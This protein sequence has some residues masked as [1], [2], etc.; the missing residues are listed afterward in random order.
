M[1]NKKVILQVL[2]AFIECT[3]VF[4]QTNVPLI[5]DPRVEAFT[6]FG[7]VPVSHTTGVPD[8]SIPLFNIES[9]GYTLP[10]TLRYHTAMVKPPYDHTNV[11]TG[12]IVEVG[13]TVVQNINGENDF[14]GKRPTTANWKND[15]GLTDQTVSSTQEYLVNA[16][17]RVY[18]CEYD[19]FSCSYPG[20][21]DK[22]IVNKNSSG[23]YDVIPLSNPNL[24]GSVIV[25]DYS[26]A[27]YKVNN[28]SVTDQNGYKYSYEKK[29]YSQVDVD[30][31]PFYMLDT[32]YSPNGHRL[33][34]FSYSA[35]TNTTNQ[36]NFRNYIINHDWTEYFQ[37]T[38]DFTGVAL[39]EGYSTWNSTLLNEN[40]S[41]GT[42]NKVEFDNGSL[43]FTLSSNHS[44]ITAI[45]LKDA[46]GN[47]LRNIE[48]QIG[49]FPGEG[50]RSLNK[51][52]LKDKNSVKISEYSFDYYNK[53]E[54]VN[55][56]TLN[57]D[58]W[59]Y[60]TSGYRPSGLL[61]QYIDI[62][63]RSFSYNRVL[64]MYEG[65]Q[66]ATLTIGQDINKEPNLNSTETYA[67]KSITYPTNGRTEF[68]YGLNQY[69][70]QYQ[71]Q[72][73]KTGG[74]LRIE[75]IIN[76]D[77]NSNQTAVKAYQYEPGSV[78][79][80]FSNDA[81]NF[82][83]SYLFQSY[84][85]SNYFYYYTRTQ[86]VSV[87]NGIINQEKSKEIRYSKVT[88]FSGTSTNNIGKTIYEYNFSNPH[89]YNYFDLIYNQEKLILGGN[90]WQYILE[91]RDWDNG[92]L[93]T[94]TIFKNNGNGYNITS[95]EKYNYTKTDLQTFENLKIYPYANYGGGAINLAQ[96]DS[97]NFFKTNANNALT[98]T[99]PLIPYNYSIKTGVSR[100]TSKVNTLYNNDG[101]QISTTEQFNY[102]NGAEKLM[103][104]KEITNSDAKISKTTYKYPYD[105]TNTATS[106]MVQ[107]NMIS[108]VVEE[109]SEVNGVH[110][111]G[112]KTDFGFLNTDGTLSTTSSLPSS[113]VIL[114][115]AIYKWNTGGFYDQEYTFDRYNNKENLLQYH[116][117]DNLN[118]S[119]IWGYNYQYPIAEIKNATYAQVTAA[120]Q[121]TTPDQLAA[122]ST[123]DISKVSA[124]WQTLPNAQVSTY[125]YTPFVGMTTASVPRGVSTNYAYDTYNRLY[126]ARN[127]D[128]NIVARYRYGYQNIPDN[129]QGGYTTLTGSISPSTTDFNINGSGLATASVSGG[130]GSYT[131]SW[132][133]LNGSTTIQTGSSTSFAFTCTQYGTLKVQCVVTDN[134]TGQVS[135][136]YKYINV[137]LPVIQF[138]N[139]QENSISSS[140]DHITTATITCDV[141]CSVAFNIS[142]FFVSGTYGIIMIGSYEKDLYTSGNGEQSVTLT[143]AKGDNL[144]TLKLVNAKSSGEYIQFDITGVDSNHS[145]SNPELVVYY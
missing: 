48:F 119:Y 62:A 35:Y 93:D 98:P 90:L 116:K 53:T 115:S 46:T 18:D 128:K 15:S 124:L 16:C 85:S 94:K 13:G 70:D 76:Y 52:I 135:V 51:I 71:N 72:G 60:L 31:F 59:G 45:S 32:I 36:L 19:L 82:R 10:V 111:K 29:I 132:S 130:S 1:K 73:L 109:I 33:F 95:T 6:I 141:A 75:E 122:S 61:G 12:W 87:N 11:A 129:G 21:N 145:I 26:I 88:E 20:G 120:L 91:Y 57:L 89:V 126:L 44:Y 140:G 28:F 50:Y 118:I 42:I 127:D 142:Y 125:A 56:S 99:V 123:P 138:S 107:R 67:L 113:A 22:F 38:S 68:I 80:S 131:Y 17:N 133:L 144:V 117:K 101:S 55:N 77:E 24:K 102:A 9:H 41:G 78:D 143:L 66:S 43:E 137:T 96:Y 106:E 79:F 37:N 58:Y 25:S 86:N 139:V 3:A 114:P 7:D 83:T 104:S 63:Q 121:G 134:L 40:W 81:D 30:K 8:I 105:L 27:A 92:Q 23:K 112:T 54:S 34:N 69:I 64:G 74:G 136:Y 47:L 108:P 100:L 14:L 65:T 110:T 4:S 39:P 2:I 84:I 5:K 103:T 49:S 97:W